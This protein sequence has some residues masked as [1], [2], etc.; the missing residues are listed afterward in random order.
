MAAY[1]GDL[2]KALLSLSAKDQFTLR[3]ACAGV[4]IF[5]GI[6][7]GK[8]SG[9]GKALA[10][11]YLR[12][13]MGGLV[14]CVKPEE[15]ELWLKYAKENGRR[16]SVVLFDAQQGFNFIEYEFA[17]QGVAGVSNVTE[18]LMRIL[19]ATDHATGAGGVSSDPFWPQSI[20]LVLNHALP[21]IYAAHGQVTIDSVIDFVTS[22][23]VK[24]EQYKNEDWCAG[25]FAASSLRKCTERA[26]VT[27]DQSKQKSLLRYWFQEFP[28]LDQKTRSNILVSLSAKL[29]RFRHG[30]L[31]SSFCSQ[32]TIVPEMTFHGA[33]IIMAMPTLTWNEDGVIGQQLFKFMWQRAVESR[34]GLAEK[35]RD[36]P[37]FLWADE[38]QYFITVKDDEFLSTC[39]GSKACVV[40]L[41]QTLPSY[42]ARLGKDKTDA[43]DGLVGK[44][45]TQVFHQ[46]ACNRTNSFASQLIGRG[47]HQRRTFSQ[48]TGHSFNE[49]MNRGGGESTQWGRNSGSSYGA[50]Q[51]S[52]NSGRSSGGG[53]SASW[54]RALVV[55]VPKA[56]QMAFR[57]KWTL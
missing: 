39:R 48:S 53:T 18:C 29:D 2:D 31:K 19:D 35:H 51:G 42:Y 49:G 41:S 47:L 40:F 16:D 30:R 3:D 28:G 12:A 37:V 20:R 56:R 36:R 13:G 52:S 45:M 21:V 11:A 5:G 24:P 26:V 33:L 38:A 6:G 8:T 14:L 57:N 23:A 4:H 54:G 7:S 1:V 15:V 27:I 46:N 17:R 25:S 32:T 50:G 34:N 9:S 44:F 10:S 43:A 22:A 55:A